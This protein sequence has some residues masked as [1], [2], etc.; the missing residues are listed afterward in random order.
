M[1]KLLWFLNPH[2][3]YFGK[4]YCFENRTFEHLNWFV[5]FWI[6]LYYANGKVQS[7][8]QRKGW[9]WRKIIQFARGMTF[10]SFYNNLGLFMDTN[11][12]THQID[13]VGSMLVTDVGDSLYWWQVWDSSK[14]FEMVVDFIHLKRH[15]H[16]DSAAIIW[17]LSS[18]LSPTSLSGFCAWV[19][20]VLQAN[21]PSKTPNGSWSNEN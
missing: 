13:R 21:Q 16:N 6:K 7:L 10:Q 8:N 20:Q 12:N 19:Y 5:I 17:K 2:F 11:N 4:K 15:Q 3:V 9:N 1:V 18:S 14:Q